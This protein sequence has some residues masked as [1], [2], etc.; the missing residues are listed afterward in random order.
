M[1]WFYLFKVVVGKSY[2]YRRRDERGSAIG[3]SNIPLDYSK[4]PLPPNYDSVYLE[5]ES[6]RK[7]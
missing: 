1:Y 5:G 6:P 3:D 7:Y 4:V 2:C